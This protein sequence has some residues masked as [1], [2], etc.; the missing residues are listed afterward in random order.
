MKMALAA[1]LGAALLG[2]GGATQAADLASGGGLKDG[3]VVVNSWAGFY[4]G[5]N[6]GYAWNDGGSVSATEATFWHSYVDHKDL[7]AD[8]GF[9]GGQIGYNWQ[10]DRLVFGIETDIQG[11]DVSN[12]ETAFA[13]SH[14]GNH[15]S[16]T[17]AKA[18]LD[19]FG[20]VRGRLGLTVLDGRG[21]AYLTGGYAYGG[22]DNTAGF[23]PCNHTA[24]NLHVPGLTQ[25]DVLSGYALG[26]GLEYAL[27]PSIS[28]KAE[29]Q[30]LDFN[31]KSYS[32]GLYVSPWHFY[33]GSAKFDNDYQ[34]VRLGINYH[35]TPAYEPL[36]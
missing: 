35:F 20:T 9:G 32:S 36:K 26:G 5:V 16:T 25:N 22:F 1:A 15:T 7:Q 18:E 11:G 6:G 33:W 31:D 23:V 13:A 2:M 12:T 30:L 28:V 24:C 29:Y 17:T 21:L 27:T 3:P 4:V 14:S 10:R 34:T 19:Y 8:G